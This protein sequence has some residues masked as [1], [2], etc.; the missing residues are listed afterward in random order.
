MKIITT[1]PA[2]CKDCYKCLRACPVKAIRFNRS[3]CN[4][5]TELHA[6]VVDERCILCGTCVQVCPQKAKKIRND[7]EI[8][9]RLLAET[10]PVALSLAPSFVAAFENC[11][12]AQLI[13]ACR[14]L[15]FDSVSETAWAA[16]YVGIEHAKYLAAMRE[17]KL[18]LLTS[19]CP[20]IV[21]L[22]ERHY[23]EVIPNLAP[24][25]S[26]MVAHT[27]YLKSLNAGRP[28]V[29]AG[30]CLAKKREGSGSGTVEA[31]ITFR[32][33][34]EMFH[35]AGI[36]PGRMPGAEL[37]GP[38]PGIARLFAL[39]GGLL[40]TASLPGDLLAKETVVITGMENCLELL[41]KLAS[42]KKLP[43]LK[44]IEMMACRSGCIN[45]P[46]FP[47]QS[48]G[49]YQRRYQVLQYARQ[50]SS[51]VQP[52]VLLP[53]ELL[54]VSYQDK[55]KKEAIPDNG[56][57]QAILAETG[58][59][60]P[61]DELNCGACGY[62]SCRDKALAVYH[63]Y[64]EIDMCIPFMRERAESMSNLALNAAP[65]G[66]IIVDADLMI[67]QMNPAAQ[68]MFACQA[69]KLIGKP[70]AKLIDPSNF[71]RI[72][73]EGNMMKITVSYPQYNLITE[74]VIFYVEKHRVVIGFFT[75]ISADQRL[76]QEM[77]ELKEA[78]VARAQEVIKNQMQVAQ[79]I[80]GLLGETTAETKVLMTKLI[81][82]MRKD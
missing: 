25:A 39:E 5:T 13:A 64:A 58:K 80:A 18:P 74:Q 52:E 78:T 4:G 12:P 45:G 49:L 19:S 77:N 17:E 33:L 34:Q 44:F 3:S 65:F 70:L 69:H 51:R 50:Q 79:E 29:F 68:E 73:K 10:R 59:V 57:I 30:P 60:E 2:Q 21:N 14:Q 81:E 36:D 8:A 28:V 55:Q 11:T 1:I 71:E 82:I 54:P 75:D 31:V 24:I 56:V 46:G 7:R 47:E 9:V 66:A 26:P 42:G 53:E 20:A 16:E 67:R 43:G 63:G 6:Q 23:P 15:G 61:H 76:K 27:R 32:E 35:E 22:I 41:E 62:P 72:H 38:Y 40:R 37:D 48:P